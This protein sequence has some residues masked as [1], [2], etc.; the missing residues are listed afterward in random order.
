VVGGGDHLFDHLPHAIRREILCVSVQ[1]QNNEEDRGTTM[2]D[3]GVL[4]QLLLERSSVITVYL[5]TTTT[6]T[7]SSLHGQDHVRLRRRHVEDRVLRLF[8]GLPVVLYKLARRDFLRHGSLPGLSCR[9]H[10]PQIGADWLAALLGALHCFP[11]HRVAAAPVWSLTV[12][13]P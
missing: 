2:I 5:V 8:D 13:L 11:H 12:A 4:C 6:I 7:P 1:T 9:H 10:S 3:N